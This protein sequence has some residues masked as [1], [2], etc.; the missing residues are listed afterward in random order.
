[1]IPKAC[2]YFSAYPG[3]RLHSNLPTGN[4]KTLQNSASNHSLAVPNTAIWAEKTNLES[5]LMDDIKN[6]FV[7]AAWVS[8]LGFILFLAGQMVNTSI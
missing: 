2:L 1:M 3:Q 6:F 8:C 4:R 5:N 7:L